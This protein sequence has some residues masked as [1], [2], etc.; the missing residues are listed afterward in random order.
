[1][2]DVEPVGRVADADYFG[3]EFMEYVRRDVIGRTVRAIDHD[4]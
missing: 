2:V 4:P 3:A 1:V